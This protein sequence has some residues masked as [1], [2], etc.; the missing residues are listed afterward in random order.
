MQVK[1]FIGDERA[2]A[3]TAVD[4]ITCDVILGLLITSANAR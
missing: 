1:E 4:S 2:M 3:V